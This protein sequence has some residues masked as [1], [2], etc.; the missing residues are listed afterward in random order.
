MIVDDDQLQI[1]I[2]LVEDTVDGIRQ[3][4]GTVA[5]RQ[6]DAYPKAHFLFIYRD[7]Q[8]AYQVYCRYGR[9][10][11]N[12][13]PGV[14]VFTPAAFGRYWRKLVEGFLGDSNKVDGLVI[15]HEDL[16]QGAMPLQ[17]LEQYLG[18]KIDPSVLDRKVGSSEQGCE[19]PWV[20]RLEKWSLRRAVSPIA[21]QQG[22]YK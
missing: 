15:H 19:K 20:S 22:Y 17:E 9:R 3:Q 21:Q 5:G 4:L 18:I 16:V 12:A 14:P 2:C 11:Y 7:P 1:L 8:D 13:W 6:Y 10:W